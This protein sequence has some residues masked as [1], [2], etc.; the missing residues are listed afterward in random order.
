MAIKI[1]LTRK[2]AKKSPYYRIIAIDSRVARDGRYI[3]AIGTYEPLK[4]PPACTFDNEI[5]DKWLKVGATPTATV[6]RL[7]RTWRQVKK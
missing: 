3:E 2:G 4:D 1:R 5:L 7:I 6:A